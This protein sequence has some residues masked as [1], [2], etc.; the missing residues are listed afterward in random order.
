MHRLSL[1]EKK[2]LRSFLN[3]TLYDLVTGE[4]LSKIETILAQLKSEISIE[5]ENEKRKVLIESIIVNILGNE[6]ATK[7]MDRLELDSSEYLAISAI[8]QQ[9]FSVT[10]YRG[11]MNEDDK[12]A[13]LHIFRKLSY[14]DLIME[15]K[16]TMEEISKSKEE[17]AKL[18]RRLDPSP[19]FPMQ[20]AGGPMGN[21]N[22]LLQ[23]ALL[24]SFAL[25]SS[26]PSSSSSSSWE[27]APARPSKRQRVGPAAP[28]SSSSSSSSSSSA[29][30]HLDLLIQNVM[31]VLG[32]EDEVIA[33]KLV[34]GKEKL[35]IHSYQLIW[36]RIKRTS[37]SD[38]PS[39]QISTFSLILNR[40]LEV[41]EIKQETRK[42]IS[43]F[44]LNL[45]H[46]AP[47]QAAAEPSAQTSPPAAAQEP[48]D[49]PAPPMQSSDDNGSDSAPMDRPVPM[50][51]NSDSDNRNDVDEGNAE[52]GFSDDGKGEADWDSTN[53]E[54]NE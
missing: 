28:A 32:T 40:L 45:P 2:S 17:I 11:T 7:L 35:D 24:A 46:P 48:I 20:A 41:K 30:S 29:P 8:A 38:V 34:M 22:P 42:E 33:G 54:E 36:K 6:K 21:Y 43:S 18:L 10:D 52:E 37:P 1:G 39:D 27:S 51:D 53:F 44:L 12:T 15:G 13:F 23:Q 19:A 4:D 31:T 25:D 5:E 14:V 50:R 49:E 9:A 16:G 26:S 47:P 3:M